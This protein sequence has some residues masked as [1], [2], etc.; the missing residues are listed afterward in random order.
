MKATH[1]PQPEDDERLRPHVPTARPGLQRRRPRRS[2]P[3][4]RPSAMDSS[5]MERRTMPRIPPLFRLEMAP[6]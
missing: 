5:S 3:T 4:E 1:Q 6:F 2:T